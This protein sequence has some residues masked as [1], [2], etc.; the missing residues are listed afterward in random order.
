MASAMATD[1]DHSMILRGLIFSMLVSVSVL[2]AGREYKC[3]TFPWSIVFSRKESQKAETGFS[4]EV[5]DEK[6]CINLQNKCD[7][8]L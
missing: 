2:L 6:N 5:R 4:L 3:S 1:T 8:L 7:F